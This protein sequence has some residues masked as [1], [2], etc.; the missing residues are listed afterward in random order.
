MVNDDQLKLVSD[1]LQ[2]ILNLNSLFNLDIQFKWILI[3]DSTKKWVTGRIKNTMLKLCFQ[4]ISIV[5]IFQEVLRLSH[6]RSLN[7][8]ASIDE[9]DDFQVWKPLSFDSGLG[10]G[11]I[12]TAHRRGPIPTYIYDLHLPPTTYTYYLRSTPTTYDL[13]VLPAT[14]TYHL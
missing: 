9:E 13:Y 6:D 4:F 11:G 14:Y 7:K 5:A 2:N 12:P 3:V 1:I 8:Y 10:H